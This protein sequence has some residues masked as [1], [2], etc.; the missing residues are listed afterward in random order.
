L[1]LFTA[2]FGYNFCRGGQ[3]AFKHLSSN[4]LRVSAINSVGDFVLFLGKALV[5]VA[6]ILIG[7]KMLDVS[8]Q[9]FVLKFL[10]ICHTNAEKL[11]IP[12]SISQC[13]KA[14]CCGRTTI[15]MSKGLHSTD[16]EHIKSLTLVP[17]PVACQRYVCCEFDHVHP[18]GHV[19]Y[20]K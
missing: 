16:L 15:L 12:C 3:Q 14:E 18:S 17:N 1:F 2:I 19:S 10:M 7:I 6:T 20:P 5:V 8:Y 9:Y 11:N 13:I 4:A